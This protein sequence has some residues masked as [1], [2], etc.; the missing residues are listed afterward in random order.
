[1]ESGGEEEQGNLL[2]RNHGIDSFGLSDFFCV[3]PPVTA[4]CSGITAQLLCTG[5]FICSHS[6]PD[7]LFSSLPVT[8]N[9]LIRNYANDP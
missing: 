2:N 6:R 4:N 8:I 3:I 7:L 5:R 1:M 9:G